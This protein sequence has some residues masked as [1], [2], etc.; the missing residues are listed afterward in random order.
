MTKSEI[1][2]PDTARNILISNQLFTGKK[3][4]NDKSDLFN[5]IEILGYVQID[6][7]SVVERSHHHVLWTRMSD[8]NRSMIDELLEKDK[9]IF[10]YWSHA[11][12]FLPMKDFRFSLLRKRNYRD[13][14]KSWGLAN[15][16]LI[17]KVYAAVKSNGP[18]LS[19][20]FAGER[21]KNTGW[22]DWKPSKDALDFLFHSGKLMVLKRKSFQ[23]VYDLTERVIPENTDTTFPSEI[24]FYKYLLYTS[25]NANGFTSEKETMYLRKYNRSLFKKMINELTEDNIISIIEIKGFENEKFYAFKNN[26]EKLFNVKKSNELFLLSPFD[27]F[28]IQRRRLQSLFNFDFQI[29]CYVPK[30]KRKFGYFCLPVLS[31]DTFIGRIDLK[32]DRKQKKLYVINFFPERNSKI[33]NKQTI[34]LKRKLMLLAEFCGCNEIIGI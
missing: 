16:K 2:T 20:D 19:K 33:N 27:N 21:K 1:I 7:I 4:L 10:E 15:K 34:D 14:Y 12:A 31:G 30:N 6:T 25:I 29:E 26:L 9:L 11:A 13:K 3:V 8:Y 17:R 28:V 23:K 32:A 18:M 24:D 22:W 5:I